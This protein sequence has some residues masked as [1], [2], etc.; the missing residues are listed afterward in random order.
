MPQQETTPTQKVVGKTQRRGPR[1]RHVPQRTCV[2]CREHDAKRALTRIVR[3]P[4]GEVQIDPSGK[5]NG[6]GAYLCDRPTCWERALST[7]LLARA[8]NTELP[9][10]TLHTLREFAAGLSNTPRD[11]VQALT[12]KEFNT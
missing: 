2:A 6:R 11:A 8:L 1:P 9:D 10:E 12:S 5:R 7:P 4:E 3:S